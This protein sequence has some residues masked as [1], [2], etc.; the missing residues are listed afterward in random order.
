MCLC[1][2]GFSRGDSRLTNQSATWSIYLRSVSI[3][4][5]KT[6]KAKTHSVKI[7]IKTA[8]TTFERIDDLI[9][10]KD[11]LDQCVQNVFALPSA[12]F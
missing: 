5:G 8:K 7:L 6:P 9:G 2:W 12:V 11:I 10:H 3:Y 1:Y 4:Q